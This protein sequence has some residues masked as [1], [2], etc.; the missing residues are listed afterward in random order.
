M[1]PIEKRYGILPGAFNPPTEA[2]LALARAALGHV[3]DVIFVLPQALPHKTYSGVPF[4]TRLELLETVTATEPRFHVAETAGGL[5]I[6]IAREL[7]RKLPADAELHFLC[8]RD[9]AERIVNWDYGVANAFE[10]M[11]HEF[12]LLVAP[13]NGDYE[14]ALQHKTRIATVDLAPAY[15]VMSATEVRDHIREGKE[16]EHLV[17]P[18]IHERVRALYGAESS[19]R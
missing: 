9:A 14:V 16:W 11:L 8:G 4:E 17:P 1:D 7:K 6:D 3:D 15:Q 5:F 2:H 19:T 18:I 12:S 13:R 10:A